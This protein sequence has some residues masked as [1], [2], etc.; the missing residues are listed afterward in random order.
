MGVLEIPGRFLCATVPQKDLFKELANKES[1]NPVT[2]WFASIPED[3]PFQ[4]VL[5][6]EGGSS[7]S[8]AVESAS[9]DV[10]EEDDVGHDVPVA[11]DVGEKLVGDGVAVDVS[12]QDATT[13]DMELEIKGFTN[14]DLS[15]PSPSVF[16]DSLSD[17]SSFFLESVASD[18]S[19]D[20]FFDRYKKEVTKAFQY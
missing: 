5:W 18:S 16:E 4:L 17:D 13:S 19:E 14:F 9:D 7:N 1:E 6:F 2:K 11:D 10:L 20:Y 3:Q 8:K 12:V 15:T